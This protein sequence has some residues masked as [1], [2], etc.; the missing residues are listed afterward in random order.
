MQNYVTTC[1]YK[2]QT[3]PKGSI[4]GQRNA[5][6]F[7]GFKQY[8][9][10]VLEYQAYNMGDKALCLETITVNINAI[11]FYKRNGYKE[12]PNFG[13]YKNR[14]NAICFKKD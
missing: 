13:K 4:K 1:F 3:V 10:D 7:N 14:V 2:L 8:D 5:F 9:F 6:S 12:I 11:I